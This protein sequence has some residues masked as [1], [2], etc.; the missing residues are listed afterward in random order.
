MTIELGNILKS[1]LEPLRV[2]GAGSN[3]FIDKLAGVVKTAVRSG[4]DS[5]NNKIL[6]SFPIACGT[7][8]EDCNKNGVYTDL[9]PN[10]NLGCIVY[11]EDLGVR[12]ISEEGNKRNWKASY[13]L[14][15]WLNQK[16]LGFDDCSITGQVVNTIINQFPKSFFNV[17]DTIYQKC[18]IEV[19]GQ[20]PKSTNPFAKYSYD[21]DK[22][23]YLMH[24]FDYF[25]IQIDFNYTVDSRCLTPFTKQTETTC[26]I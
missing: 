18:S 24:P 22:T 2:G 7:S 14:V 9:V 21:E 5:N 17:T 15:G 26:N 20:D 6:Q 10:S 16:K 4:K 8:F 12:L 23:Q 19:L 25:S 1:F 3:Q 11:F 13:R